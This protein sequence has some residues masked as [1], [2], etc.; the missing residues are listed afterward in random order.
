MLCV[1]YT[2]FA[3]DG[4]TE[5]DIR[6]VLRVSVKKNAQL[7]VTGVLVYG[8][9]LF[10]Q[11][12]EGPDSSVRTLLR[13]IAADPRNHGMRMVIEETIT[14]RH[15]PEWAMAYGRLD[16]LPEAERK[17]CRQLAEAVPD[18]CMGPL[19]DEFAQLCLAFRSL[20]AAE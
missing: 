13:T 17:H 12:L 7:G 10:L 16:R 18:T 15:F 4:V 2:S 1:L 5:A 6:D 14:R 8:D 11:V 20:L 19:R 3:R 9:G